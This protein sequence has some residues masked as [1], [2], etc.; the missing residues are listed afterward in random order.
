MDNNNPVGRQSR[1]SL[2]RRIVDLLELLPRYLYRGRGRRLLR[3]SG[4]LPWLKRAYFEA[5]RRSAG[6][7]RTVAVGDHS[8]TFE[9][10]TY[11]EYHVVKVADEA[12]RPVLSRLLGHVRPD[13]VFYDVGANV[14]TFTC[15]VGRALTD[16]EVVA[17]EPYPPN[18]ERLRENAARN[19][20]D[21][22]VLPVALSE[23]R[24][25]VDLNVVDSANPGTQE[26][27]I[28]A[29]YPAGRRTVET[30]TVP[31]EAGDSI[32]RG[33]GLPAPTVV[34]IDTEGSGPEV[35]RGFA[36]TLRRD[37]CR[38]VCVEPHGNRA[39]I[40]SALSGL[41]FSVDHVTLAGERRVEDPTVLGIKRGASTGAEAAG[42]A[43]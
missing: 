30:V 34:K 35:I 15:L 10:S 6:G 9:V 42:T 12:E 38:L 14:G 43:R 8:A 33:E 4:L 5:Y 13:D 36:E 7:R 32:V 2:P 19:G 40:E 1:G 27:S 26:S 11:E 37:D 29:A 41:G 23:R 31:V 18:V 39:E 20:V 24:G 21:A 28:D 16:G 17:F 3:S 22:R 25:E